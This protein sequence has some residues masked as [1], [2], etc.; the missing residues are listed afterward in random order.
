[1]WKVLCVKNC[2]AGKFYEK[3]SVGVLGEKICESDFEVAWTK[4][5]PPS[6]AGVM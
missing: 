5:A 6:C 3:L 2:T 4:E 1:M